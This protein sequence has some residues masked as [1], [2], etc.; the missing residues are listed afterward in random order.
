MIRLLLV[1]IYLLLVQPVYSIEVVDDLGY[2]VVLES[3]ARKIISLSPHNTENLFSAGAGEWIVGTV[4]YSDHPAAASDIRRVG[5]SKQASYEV[6]ITLDP[7]LV[8][9]W[10]SGNSSAMLKRLKNLG[11][12][13]FYSEPR[14]FEQVIANI[15]KLSILADT[16]KQADIEIDRLTRLYK[17]IESK[18][19][20]STPVSV[21]YQVWQQPLITLNRRHLVSQAISLC[22]GEN[23]FADLRMIAPTV[24]IESLLVKDPAVIIIG[25]QVDETGYAANWWQKWPTLSAVRMGRVYT[26]NADL[27]HRNSARFIEG[28]QEVCSILD[29]VRNANNTELQ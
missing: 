18:Y 14:R 5:S 20:N 8:V 9:V 26:V 21:F 17:A 15:R 28:V 4:D 11:L 12:T 24:S 22:G 6:I 25:Q 1:L 2:R 23:I 3:P 10:A 16:R 27:L 19:A 13:L 29:Q 7:D